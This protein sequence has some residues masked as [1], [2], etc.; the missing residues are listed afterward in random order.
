M[1]PAYRGMGVNGKILSYLF[2]WG[3]A[4]GYEEFQLTVYAENQSAVKAYQKAGF[5]PEI[6][7]MRIIKG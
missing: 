3:K 1:V 5:E 6:F 4:R 7:M 2:E